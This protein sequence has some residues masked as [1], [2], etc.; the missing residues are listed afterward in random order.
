MG[1]AGYATR[2]WTTPGTRVE[3]IDPDI[4]ERLAS[5]HEPYP[6]A[7]AMDVDI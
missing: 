6:K 3:R 1:E 5:K 7:V 4:V 2:P